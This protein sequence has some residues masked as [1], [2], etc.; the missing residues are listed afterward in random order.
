MNISKDS[1]NLLIENGVLILPAILDEAQLIKI[2]NE[3]RASHNV[4]FNDRLGSLLISDNLWIEH[5]ALFSKASLETVLHP[6]LLSLLDSYL[7]E[8]AILG[9]LKYQKK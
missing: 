9:S 5:L 3:I 8:E 4:N 7:G 6:N 2:K 1:L